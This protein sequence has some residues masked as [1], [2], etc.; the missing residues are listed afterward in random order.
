VPLL[1]IGLYSSR[2][3]ASTLQKATA[4][5]LLLHQTSAGGGLDRSKGRRH[6]SSS[7]QPRHRTHAPSFSSDG[8]EEPTTSDK[9][10]WD[11]FTSGWAEAQGWWVSLVQHEQ[12]ADREQGESEDEEEALRDAGVEIARLRQEVRPRCTRTLTTYLTT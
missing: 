12:Q 6:R 8:D 3:L 5:E 7:P 4:R 11:P 10:R 9:A 1:A 2:A